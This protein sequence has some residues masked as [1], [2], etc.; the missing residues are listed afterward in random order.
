MIATASRTSYR[1][2]SASS[3]I[4]GSP[5]VV[6]AP[7]R[8]SP[9]PDPLPACGERGVLLNLQTRFRDELLPLRG[10]GLNVLRKLLRR[11]ADRLD[12]TIFERL[13]HF[14][15]TQRGENLLVQLV[16]DR[17]GRFCRREQT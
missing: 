11:I 3:A 6:R 13:A 1:T 2:R 4:A 14:G 15:R 17:L 10:L 16:D 9:H 12:H 5:D 8:I 7:N